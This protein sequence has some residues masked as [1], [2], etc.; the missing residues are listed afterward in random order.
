MDKPGLLL[1]SKDD[2]EWLGPAVAGAFEESREAAA[3]RRDAKPGQRARRHAGREPGQD[4][5]RSIERALK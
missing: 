4:V 2:E 1:L 3:R 5:T